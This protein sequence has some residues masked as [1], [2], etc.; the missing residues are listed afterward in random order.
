MTGEKRTIVASPVASPVKDNNIRT[1]F[2]NFITNIDIR[3]I[4]IRDIDF[5]DFKDFKDV[6]YRTVNNNDSDSDSDSN[7]NVNKMINILKSYS[8]FPKETTDVAKTLSFTGGPFPDVQASS[9]DDIEMD[10]QPEPESETPSQDYS[11][12][13]VEQQ[14]QQQAQPQSN[15]SKMEVD[16]SESLASQPS[17]K[18][19]NEMEEESTKPS[20]TDENEMEEESTKP[21]ETDETYYDGY[22]FKLKDK[23]TSQEGK[24]ESYNIEYD[25][26]DIFYYNNYNK[27][28]NFED[29]IKNH[30]TSDVDV[31]SGMKAFESTM[32]WF[33]G[34]GA[35]TGF[36]QASMTSRMAAEVTNIIDSMELEIV[37]LDKKG[38]VDYSDIEGRIEKIK[39]IKIEGDQNMEVS[40]EGGGINMNKDKES[41]KGKGITNVE[42][43]DF[44]LLTGLIKQRAEIPHDFKHPEIKD[45]AIMTFK[46]IHNYLLKNVDITQY[47]DEIQ[48]FI[49]KLIIKDVPDKKIFNNEWEYYKTILEYVTTIFS[50][51]QQV[52]EKY[53]Y[54]KSF[55]VNY[56]TKTDPM[57]NIITE[58]IKTFRESGYLKFF[59]K[60][61]DHEDEKTIFYCDELCR[62]I[63]GDKSEPIIDAK[64]LKFNFNDSS[65]GQMKYLAPLL[66]YTERTLEEGD[67]EKDNK[68]KLT[69]RRGYYTLPV[70][71]QDYKTNKDKDMQYINRYGYNVANSLDPSV[72]PRFKSYPSRGSDDDYC[73]SQSSYNSSGYKNLNQLDYDDK[74]FIDSF[75]LRKDKGLDI[76]ESNIFDY[77][78]KQAAIRTFQHSIKKFKIDSV[79]IEDVYFGKDKDNEEDGNDNDREYSKVIFSVTK[80]TS[81]D[82]IELEFVNFKARKNPPNSIGKVTEALQ[83][84]LYENDK[85]TPKTI[86]KTSK[87]S[88]FVDNYLKLNPPEESKIGRYGIERM[89]FFMISIK[90]DG[91]A[92]QVEYMY[93][94]RDIIDTL[95]DIIKK[96]Y[97]VNKEFKE[98]E[99]KIIKGY[100]KEIEKIQSYKDRMFIGT[101]DKNVFAHAVL[102]DVPCVMTDGGIQTTI[103]NAEKKRWFFDSLATEKILN[104]FSFGLGEDNDKRVEE[105]MKVINGSGELDG[106]KRN[107]RTL[108]CI[109]SYGV[110]TKVTYEEDHVQGIRDDILEYLK[111]CSKNNDIMKNY[112]IDESEVKGYIDGVFKAQGGD[113]FK[114][115]YFAYKMLY[116]DMLEIVDFNKTL[117]NIIESRRK[118]NEMTLNYLH[119]YVFGTNNVL[120][121]EYAIQVKDPDGINESL[122]KLHEMYSKNM[123][124]EKYN[125]QID[126]GKITF[127]LEEG[128]NVEAQYRGIMKPGVISRD[129]RDGTFDV[130]YDD[131]VK[132]TRVDESL[133]RTVEASSNKSLEN[134][135][136][137]CE[138]LSGRRSISS[139]VLG[140]SV[141]QKLTAHVQTMRGRMKGKF[142]AREDVMSILATIH[143]MDDIIER[144]Y[145][146]TTVRR[147]IPGFREGRGKEL[148]D[149]EEDNDPPTSGPRPPPLGDET[150]EQKG[151]IGKGGSSSSSSSSSS[152][153]KVV[154]METEGDTTLLDRKKIGGPSESSKDDETYELSDIEDINIEKDIDTDESNVN[155]RQEGDLKLVDF[156]SEDDYSSQNYLP[157]ERNPSSVSGVSD[158]TGDDDDVS[159]QR[160]TGPNIEESAS[161]IPQVPGQ[162]NINENVL[163]GNFIQED[164]NVSTGTD[165]THL[166]KKRPVDFDDR[167][168]VIEGEK[169][170]KSRNQNPSE[171]KAPER[172]RSSTF[173]GGLFSWLTGGSNNSSV[174]KRNRNGKT[175]HVRF[176]DSNN[177]GGKNKTRKVREWRW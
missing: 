140:D 123:T 42:V 38:N 34:I 134:L 102:Q 16:P 41:D 94:Y 138:A 24:V 82:K 125:K 58:R 40:S 32:S 26:E 66:E 77:V 111:R 98:E 7:K 144:K 130:N 84:Y 108:Q 132:Q 67:E 14:P 3:D 54:V 127:R 5:K 73:F 174:V 81:K 85:K 142:E 97:D 112:A 6:E 1:S 46:F 118:I 83:S 17:E 29:A 52:N 167:S 143:D 25:D 59:K 20:E 4:D 156:D 135:R 47:N 2:E 152:S 151:N 88:V 31:K 100:T 49:K 105:L 149:G 169:N 69:N 68:L 170:K 57:M 172:K 63:L 131:G 72:Q 18:D 141:Q 103:E 75:L 126:T 129:N 8:E 61:R 159:Y 163:S 117:D 109:S 96:G 30:V 113:N 146:K 124:K 65:Y 177:G 51:K 168:I 122:E 107:Y 10:V 158:M 50:G 37:K 74:K 80:G 43:K 116:E 15:D 28:K 121:N 147:L 19:E 176:K 33:E 39:E 76:K 89:L 35:M 137:I 87:T 133:I 154:K 79:T 9:P 164:D 55:T 136:L 155:I 101:V 23:K 119:D 71:Y 13:D 27:N 114:D 90:G 157:L 91:D 106:P 48:N 173:G 44:L 60:T 175:R 62:P 150:L 166:S 95:G 11:Q 92:N 21:S 53:R 161:L 64:K 165:S 93:N 70:F 78:A 99:I 45:I 115:L 110:S 86:A 153:D 120:M 56:E 145:K 139:N 171:P 22:G 160:V 162:Y 128:I 12:M 36:L 104:T 148:D